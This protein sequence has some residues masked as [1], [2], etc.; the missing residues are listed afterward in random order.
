MAELS[1]YTE[2][3]LT[4]DDRPL[5]QEAEICALHGALRGAYILVWIACAEGLKR[6]F[7]EAGLRDNQANKMLGEIKKVE[8]QEKSAD[9]IILTKA[10]DYGFIDPV[11]FQKLEYIYKMRCVYGHPYEAAPREEELTNAAAIVVSEVLGKPTFLKQGF[12]QPLINNLFSDIN[13]LEQTEASVRSFAE[14]ISPRVAPELYDYVLKKYAEKLEPVYDDASL[15]IVVERG[16]WFLSEFLLSVGGDFYSAAQWHDFAQKYP[17]T[18]QHILLSDGRL[19]RAIGERARDYII[20][21]NIMNARLRPSRLKSIERLLSEGVLSD[22]QKRKLQSLDIIVIKV[23]HLKIS[24]CYDTILSALESHDW[25]NQNPAVDLIAMNDRSEIALLLP[26]QQEKLGRNIL[27]SAEGRSR[28][29]LIFLSK[30]QENPSCLEQ[31]FLKGLIFEAFVNERLELRFK[32]RCIENVLDVLTKQ[33]DI[34]AELAEAIDVSR[35]KWRISKEDY[36]KVI[37]LVRSRPNVELLADAIERC[38]KKLIVADDDDD[39][40]VDH[41]SSF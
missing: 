11:A 26:E 32:G 20:S 33:K 31:P 24:T 2:R 22:V 18:A 14:E 27:Q 1:K 25:N 21:Y 3:I 28:S 4:E 12:V 34:E 6:K 23:A 9:K 35:P 38:S 7:L 5:F 36:Q 29:A 10:K 40:Q 19:F 17:K 16:L 8:E 13:Y 41:I 15:H 39:F 37:D 30:I